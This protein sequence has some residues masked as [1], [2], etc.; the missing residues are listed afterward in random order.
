MTAPA[1][2]TSRYSG[3]AASQGMTEE[4]VF[5]AD[6]ERY[7]IRMMGFL[8]WS[9]RQMRAYGEAGGALNRDG[10]P[11]D[12]EAYAV[13]LAARVNAGAAA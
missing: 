10:A 5:V 1:K 12:R 7:P 13:W 9:K 8:A 6:G 4:E 11:A 3:Y 2:W